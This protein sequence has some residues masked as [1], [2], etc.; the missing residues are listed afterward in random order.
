MA[1]IRFLVKNIQ[2]LMKAL[3]R[4]PFKFLESP[5]ASKT[6]TFPGSITYHLRKK[7]NF[8]TKQTCAFKGVG[9]SASINLERIELAVKSVVGRK[10]GTNTRNGRG[11][12]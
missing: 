3:E 7:D 10:N 9:W 11:N 6:F 8:V 1:S 4:F 2:E 12:K 5:T